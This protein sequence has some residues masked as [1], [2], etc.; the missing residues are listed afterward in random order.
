MAAGPGGEGQGL[1][2]LLRFMKRRAA[3]P[4]LRKGLSRE[5]LLTDSLNLLQSNYKKSI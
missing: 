4:A 1:S 3:V 2:S 5:Q